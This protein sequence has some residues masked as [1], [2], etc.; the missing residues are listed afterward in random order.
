[1]K[2]FLKWAGGKRWLVPR[3]IKSLPLCKK[4][5]ET[6]LGG[7]A[8]YFALEP[9]RAILSDTNRDLIECYSVVRDH[10]SKLINV[11]KNLK[12]SNETY[13][14]IRTS[15]NSGIGKIRKA[16]YFIYLN[17][18]CW[19]GLYRVNRDG[20]FNV[21]VGKHVHQK[22]LIYD[23]SHLRSASRLLKKAELRCCDFEAATSNV[24]GTNSLVY[25]D[26]P[27][28]TTHVQNGFIQY[29]SVLFSEFDELRL[30]KVVKKLSGKNV[31]VLLSNAAHPVIKAQY[32]GFNK[33]EISRPSLIAN[34]PKKRTKFNE[35]LVTNF[36]WYADDE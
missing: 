34:D 30:A 26:P 32:N 24:R 35:L 23:E 28:I 36:S 15:Y 10:C 1:M 27:Y 21:P 3:I 20:K 7:G 4:Y 11:L 29:N 14:E 19:N 6:F 9:P 5:Y 8:L 17:K 18:M 25:F 16:A 2:P 12:I 22:Y 31:K 33:T 13:Y